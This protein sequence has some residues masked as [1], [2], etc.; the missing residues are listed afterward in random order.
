MIN[1]SKNGY[2]LYE[3]WITVERGRAIEIYVELSEIGSEKE[4]KSTK[5]MIENYLTVKSDPAYAD[6]YLDNQFIGKTP[7]LDYRILAESEEVKDKIL[8]ITKPDYRPYEQTIK[9]TDLRNGI[10]LHVSTIKLLPDL[11]KPTATVNKPD[12]RFIVTTPMIVLV[13]LLTAILAI[14]VVTILIRRRG[15]SSQN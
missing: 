7:V 6:A 4:A 14:W 5:V 9:G 13:V 12:K 3:E 15:S 1:I 2:N 8:K 10:K 11:T